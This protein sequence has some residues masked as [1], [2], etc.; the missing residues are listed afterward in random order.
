ML[1]AG[2]GSE[3][4]TSMLHVIGGLHGAWMHI[5]GGDLIGA[6]LVSLTVAGCI[7]ILAGAVALSEVIRVKSRRYVLR[8]EQRRFPEQRDKR[9]HNV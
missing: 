9:G 4:V 6:V 7:L 5:G 3:L 1:G 8:H 2:R